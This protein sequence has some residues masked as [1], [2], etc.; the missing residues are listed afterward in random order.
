MADVKTGAEHLRSLRDGR[1][2]YIDGER[3][4]DVTAHPAFRNACAAAASLYDYQARPE[5][6][7]RM[8]FAA[9]GAETGGYRRM[10]RAWQKP[11]T[12]EELVARRRA[13]VEWAELSCGFL[14]R[15]PDHVASALV[16]QVLGIEVF[17]RHGEAR[18]KAL[19]DYFDYVSRND[20][21]LSYVIINPQADRSKGVG[22]AAARPRRAPRRRGQRRYHR[23]RRQDARHRHDSGERAAGRQSTA[24][25][26]GRRRPRHIV[27]RPGG[28]P[29]PEDPVAQILRGARGLARRQSALLTLRRE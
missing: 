29:G 8:T 17:R 10:N 11:R 14:G 20:L 24:A 2:V 25:T 19:L 27:R 1:A 23:A 18:A 7:D 21:Y 5:N 13:L 12:Y 22:R 3:V 9:E 26:A 6:L 15:A 28:D 16:G 4:E